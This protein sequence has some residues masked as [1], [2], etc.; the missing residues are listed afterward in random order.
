MLMI[1]LLL[2]SLISGEG[3]A[4]TSAPSSF[5]SKQST[6]GATVYSQNPAANQLFLQAREYY[7]KSDPRIA[8]GKL[9]NARAAIKLYEQAVQADP[10]FALA[11][12]EM[13]RAWLRLGYSDPDG[14]SNEALLPPAKAALLKALS[15]DNKLTDVHL[16]L[17]ALYYNLDYDW[18][19]A[20]REYQ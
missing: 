3:S 5:E 11:Y 13:S 2:G 17:A 16:T 8:G 14:L 10:K 18:A 9:A 6:T 7:N 12:V 20:E 4:Q 19:G 1:F 15:I